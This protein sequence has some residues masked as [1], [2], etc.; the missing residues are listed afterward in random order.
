MQLLKL[1]EENLYQEICKLYD[2]KEESKTISFKITKE[3]DDPFKELLFKFCFLKNEGSIIFKDINELWIFKNNKNPHKKKLYLNIIESLIS[4]SNNQH[5][6]EKQKY[7]N[8]VKD[9]INYTNYEKFSIF[10]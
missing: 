7:F 9:Y 3:N 6:D 4:L 1:K 2:F 8:L 5:L 10:K